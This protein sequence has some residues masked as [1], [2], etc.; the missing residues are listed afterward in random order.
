MA[1][2]TNLRFQDADQVLE[3][4]EAL[5][6]YHQARC[7]APPYK[8]MS[9]CDAWELHLCLKN[10]GRVFAALLDLRLA[11]SA[12]E[13]ELSELARDV[14]QEA[15]REKDKEPP[16]IESRLQLFR[17]NSSYILRMRS[18]L[19]KIM[20]F[21]VLTAHPDKFEA[22][23]R[24]RSRRRAFASLAGES[25]P[26][27]QRLASYVSDF[28]MSLDERYRTSEAHGF[29]SVRL[30]V[31]GELDGS[32]GPQSEMFS[33][34]NGLLPLLQEIAVAMRGVRAKFA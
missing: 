8:W 4:E 5:A 6:S 18:I 13:V 34:W 14:N 27:L 21:V 22:F 29:G 10:G 24:K 2:P 11:V 26:G 16:D 20:A 28:A 9:L 25:P 31:F 15:R 17:T 12:L 32:D 33:A 19:D 7:G 30:W 23:R 3:F 1:I